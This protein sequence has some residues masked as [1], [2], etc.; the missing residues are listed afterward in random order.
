MKR[1]VRAFLIWLALG[2]CAASVAALSPAAP[3]QQVAASAGG[4]SLAAAQGDPILEAMLTELERSKTQLKMEDVPAPYFVEYRISD[5]NLY[6]AEAAFGA[7]LRDQWV[8]VR[9]LSVVVRVG[10]YKRD[11]YAG[12]GVG[13]V[14]GVPID[15]DPMAIRRQ[16]WLATDRAYKQAAE[17]L[18]RRQAMARQFNED[19]SISDFARE[20]A[21]QI[22]EPPVK[23]DADPAPWR[24][25]LVSATAL[26]RDYPEVQ[27][28]S[29]NLTFSAI[30]HYY[31]NSEGAVT[32]RGPRVLSILLS[33]TT[34]AADGMQLVRTPYYEVSDAKELP[35]PQRLVA[36]TRKMLETLKSLRQAPIVEEDY[37]GPVLFSND[38]ASDVFADLVAANV[39]GRK[40]Q[41]GTSS[42][43]VGAYSSSYKTRVL[44]DFLSVVDNPTLKTF[45]GHTAAG[46][47]S[48]DDEGTKAE[49]VTVVDKGLLVNYLLGRAP[50][51][52]F[53][54]SNG[55]GRV[56]PGRAAFPVIGNLIV[57]AANTRS[58]QE[59][60]QQLIELC[61]QQGRD[62]GY[63]VET[64][65]GL[66]N[67]RLLYRVWVKDGHEELV[68]GAV[69]N[70]LDVRTLR[71]NL[72]AAGNDPLVSNRQGPIPT[73][74][75]SPS[76]LFDE[77]EVRR[78]GAA[79]ERLPDYPQPP[80]SS[81]SAAPAHP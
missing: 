40:P 42:R 45:E 2:G 30:S 35:S 54:S 53:P 58:P 12:G 67:P 73:T 15:E 14:E 72:I 63:L 20:P 8:H 17:A 23:L 38:A 33:G 21:V 56:V 6:D 57:R 76:I 64:L 81:G 39:I 13:A 61:R 34:Q 26:F 3:S 80:L 22:L 51:R 60:K 68:R 47:Y 70:E 49:P 25:A 44:P 52:D 28:V 79:K 5:A 75:I 32:R 66:L 1:R 78:S 74:V 55:H 48:V 37:L 50:I 59:L 41:P 16:I 19:D 7:L 77:L 27:S 65:G 18:T 10:D 69:F 11:S 71:N 29:A 31:V 62:Y 4:A 36:D 9:L 43:T 24:D 46:S